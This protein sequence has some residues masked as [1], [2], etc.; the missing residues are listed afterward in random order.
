MARRPSVVEPSCYIGTRARVAVYDGPASAPL[1]EDVAPAPAREYI[2]ALSSKVFELARQRGGSVPY[3]VIRELAENLLHAGFADPV[4]SILDHGR[5]ISFSDRGPGIPD[6][7]RA[8]RPG[9]TT[10][11]AAMKDVI[12]GVGSGLPIVNDFLAATGGSLS[13]ED[14]LAGGSVVTITHAAEA[15]NTS[16]ST[17]RAEAPGT[18]TVYALSSSASP[19][20]AESRDGTA[21]HSL[22]GAPVGDVRL[23]T[24]QKHVLALVLETGLAGPSIVSRELGI[25]LSTAYR[26]LAS[27]E[28]MGL[29]TSDGGK[30]ML[31]EE[32]SSLLG[33]LMASVPAI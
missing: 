7:G 13:I 4:I 19:R 5:T 9:F 2:E 28:E 30:R 26:D 12:R 1:V 6:K 32:G 16:N 29:I 3:T 23:S 20:A 15:P 21:S 22:F 24:R 31:T 11:T 27:L 17:V 33:K 14:N 25:G 8:L 18:A 10:A